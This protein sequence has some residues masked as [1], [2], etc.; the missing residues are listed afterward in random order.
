MKGKFGKTSKI[1]KIVVVV[2][3][4]Q[5]F[6]I[7]TLKIKAN[8]EER[9]NLWGSVLLFP[10]PHSAALT[11]SNNIKE[12]CYFLPAERGYSLP[13]FLCKYLN[14]LIFILSARYMSNCVFE[15][16]IQKQI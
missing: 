6:S 9:N 12:F 2:R 10:V 4:R 15:K 13:R 14:L 5:Y 7:S 1:F 8:V 16:V 3:I 11:S